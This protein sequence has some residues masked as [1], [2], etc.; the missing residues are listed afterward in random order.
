MEDAVEGRRRVGMPRQWKGE[1][2]QGGVW[3]SRNAFRSVGAV[4]SMTSG[5]FDQRV[6]FE[7]FQYRLADGQAALPLRVAVL[8]RH[9]HGAT[10]C[11]IEAARDTR[12][13]GG[14]CREPRYLRAKGT[15]TFAHP[16]HRAGGGMLCPLGLWVPEEESDA[17]P[18]HT[19]GSRDDSS[20]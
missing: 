13:A 17:M 18:P 7:R 20:T 8:H 10:G 1:R 2:A 5:S 16:H 4:S 14:G 15:G 9:L 11:D 6:P 12:S 19:R 3:C